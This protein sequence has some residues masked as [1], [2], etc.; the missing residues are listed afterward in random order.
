MHEALTF[1][2]L[3]GAL[4]RARHA[5][6]SGQGADITELRDLL[7]SV[8][9]YETPG[10]YRSIYRCRPKL[11]G[12]FVLRHIPN[13]KPGND[14]NAVPP[15]KKSG[16]CNLFAKDIEQSSEP[17]FDSL[18]NAIWNEIGIAV[19]KGQFSYDENTKA[20]RPFTA[21]EEKWIDIALAGST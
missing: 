2:F 8:R 18:A 3:I 1:P 9:D 12:E 7:E 11:N 13:G 14:F 19:S 16:S 6:M 20:Y 21:N 10:G 15:E 17:P 5:P 4:R